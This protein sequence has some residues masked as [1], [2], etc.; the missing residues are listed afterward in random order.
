MIYNRNYSPSQIVID[1]IRKGKGKEADLDELIRVSEAMFL[2][3]FCALGQSPVMPIKSAINN[4]KE[5]FLS[6]MK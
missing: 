1:K 3:S 2:T 4:F 5:D 6:R